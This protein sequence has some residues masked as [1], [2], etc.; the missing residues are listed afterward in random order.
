[1]LID[2]VL[3][4]GDEAFVHKCLDKIS[5]FR[6]RNKTIILVTHSL[7]LVE[8]MAD[9][10]LWIDKSEVQLRGDPKKVVD[11]YLARVSLHEENAL[12][13]HEGPAEHTLAPREPFMVRL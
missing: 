5:E 10:A 7:G 3:A 1:L 4:V 8:K 9:E 13:G 6:R 2:E 11:A 12:D